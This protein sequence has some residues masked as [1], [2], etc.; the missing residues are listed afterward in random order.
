MDLA[1]NPPPS[2]DQSVAL[3]HQ[4]GDMGPARRQPNSSF[5]SGLG[6]SDLAG[7]PVRDYGAPGSDSEEAESVDP[8]AVGADEGGGVMMEDMVYGPMRDFR[9]PEHEARMRRLQQER[10]AGGRPQFGTRPSDMGVPRVRSGWD[11]PPQLPQN[12]ISNRRGRAMVRGTPTAGVGSD[13]ERPSVG[14][15]LPSNGQQVSREPGTAQSVTIRIFNYSPDG[16]QLAKSLAASLNVTDYSHSKVDSQV[17]IHL[18]YAGRL[19]QVAKQLEVG[20]L[21]RMDTLQRE[22]HVDASQQRN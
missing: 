6:T 15:Q 1:Y 14:R 5:E 19:S 18:Q 4:S 12:G 16:G 22:I 20:K 7:S 21:I 8:F 9:D 11:G 17:T 13:A 2:S 3:D 10:E